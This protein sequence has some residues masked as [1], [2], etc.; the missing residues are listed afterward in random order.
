MWNPVPYTF[1]FKLYIY[2]KNTEDCTKIVE[3]ILPYFTPS[4][5][6]IA[7]MIPGLD[8]P[9]EMPITLNTVEFSDNYEAGFQQ[10]RAIIWTLDFTM[11]GYMYGPTFAGK[12]IKFIDANIYVA[13]TQVVS[14]SVG[15][16]PVVAAM[17]IARAGGLIV[18]TGQGC[19]ADRRLVHC[20]F[21]FE[22]LA[23][24]HR[25]R[26]LRV[27]RGKIDARCQELLNVPDRAH[28]AP[29][30]DFVDSAG[31]NDL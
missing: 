4:W 10:R 24:D 3:Q 27:Q 23:A 7:D 25:H 18:E 2:G 21:A 11:K 17:T 14:D 8:T 29:R 6:V 31:A 26:V 12:I 13:N 1:G 9:M 22:C 28:P 20:R 19:Q 16:V 30:G 15:N 5:T